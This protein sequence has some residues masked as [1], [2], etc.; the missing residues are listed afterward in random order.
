MTV[1]EDTNLVQRTTPDHRHPKRN[2]TFSILVTIS[3]TLPPFLGNM[4]IFHQ[5]LD[6]GQTL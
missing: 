6:L 2:L 4:N 1:V 5:T 3:L